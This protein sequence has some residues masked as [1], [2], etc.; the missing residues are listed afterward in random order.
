M[1]KILTVFAAI[2]MLGMVSCQ[3][4]SK[5]EG[6]D[7]PSKDSPSSQD[8]TPS[9]DPSKEP[10]AP[11]STECRLLALK[12][13]VGSN[14][15]V[16]TLYTDED[17]PEYEFVYGEDEIDNFKAARLVATISE[18][19][20]TNIEENETYD[21]IAGLTI[22]VTAE[23]GKTKREYAVTSIEGVFETFCDQV[24]ARTA[25][26]ANCTSLNNAN[27]SGPIVAFAGVDKIVYVDGTVV[28]LESAEKV[29]TLN[30]EG[31]KS[32]NFFNI[33]NDINGIVIAA[34]SPEAPGDDIQSYY[35]YAWL[36]GYDKAPTLV[37]EQE[38]EGPVGGGAYRYFSCGGDIFGDFV[39]NYIS[40]AGEAPVLH[41]VFVVKDGDFEGVQWNEFYSEYKRAD[42]NWG[43]M[44]SPAS[45]D[46]NDWWFIGDSHGNN[47]GYHVYS[48]KGLD[49]EDKVLFGQVVDLGY[50]YADLE[51]NNQYGNYSAGNVRGF[52][53]HGKA[54]V[55]ASTTGWPDTYVTVQSADPEDPI[56]YLMETKQYAYAQCAPSAAYVYDA[57]TD[58]GHIVMV[59]AGHDSHVPQYVVRYDV[60]R[61]VL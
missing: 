1:K 44:I 38:N 5:P 47:E 53:F 3:P 37:Y 12:A 33:S 24:W 54:Y 14:Q 42:G 50:G 39:F 23:D 10:E 18:G 28:D 59:T 48:R 58:T 41:N 22:T 8:P 57:E 25:T 16:G 20:T 13:I 9:D 45:G 46:P 49:G 36:D 30:M 27:T 11:K 19:A 61:E 4:E 17:V 60:T 31:C 29:G 51:V 55:V 35:L 52:S 7:D 26:Q 56:H 21:L 15:A 43:Q 6:T 40:G 32:D 34:A 2:A